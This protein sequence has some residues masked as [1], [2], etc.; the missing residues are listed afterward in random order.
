MTALP[1]F[2]SPFENFPDPKGLGQIRNL[3]GILTPDFGHFFPKKLLAIYPNATELAQN[4][5]SSK[6][7]NLFKKH[8][9]KN[10]NISAQATDPARPCD[11]FSLRITRQ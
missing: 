10:G 4:A 3:L 1:N 11:R 2:I 9:F 8:T 7:S 6:D 5:R